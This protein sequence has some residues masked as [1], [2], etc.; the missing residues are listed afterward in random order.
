MEAIFK[1]QPRIGIPQTLVLIKVPGVKP[2]IDPQLLRAWL[3][4][5]GGQRHRAAKGPKNLFDK[6]SG[7][8]VAAMALFL[9]ALS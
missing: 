5:D 9:T 8:H 6:S 1:P 7:F 2:D 4:I 3:G